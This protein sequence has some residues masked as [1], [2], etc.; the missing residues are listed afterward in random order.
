MFEPDLKRYR[1][2]EPDDPTPGGRYLEPGQAPGVRVA[3]DSLMPWFTMPLH[4]VTFNGPLHVGICDI[5][6]IGVARCTDSAAHLLAAA[7][8]AIRTLELCRAHL[9]SIANCEI[10]T[11]RTAEVLGRVDRVVKEALWQTS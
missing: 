5:N 4:S 7:P 1:E 2:K 6:G 11:L 3:V 10:P 9:T 8:L